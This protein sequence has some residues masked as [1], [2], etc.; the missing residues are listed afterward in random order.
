MATAFDNLR[1]TT[2]F[3]LRLFG[4]LRQSGVEI[5]MQQTIA[6]MHAIALLGVV[7][8]D[9]LK[10]IYKAT[11]INRREDLF[12]L[13]RIYELL[14]KAYLAP[15]TTAQDDLKELDE[16][17]VVTIKR[18]QQSDGE[19]P[20]DDDAE[21]AETEGYSVRE[22]DHH[23]DFQ[24]IPKEEVPAV[25]VELEKIARKYA[26]IARRKKKAKRS[27]DIDLRASV[28]DSLKFDGEIVTWRY[29]QKTPTHSRFVILS[30][31]SGSM[32]I[33]SV[34][35]LNFLYLLHKNQKMKVESFVFSTR[36]QALT[37]YFRLRN[38]Q[39]MLKNVSMHFSG[40][41]GGTKIGQAIET[42][43]REFSSTVTPKTTVIIMS[44]G[45]DTGD[46]ALLDR[47]MAR[48]C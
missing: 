38:F 9:E 39:E 4:L 17:D 5:G 24:L 3:S 41:S 33:Y 42:L 30:D 29:K 47:E 44:D 28:R 13:H 32:E 2:D 1:I 11:L 36:L 48:A 27:G 31:V 8:Q 15:R 35:L 26:A 21:L 25:M 43:N 45:W 19:S 46:I 7:N 23:K 10:G 12:Q 18:R 6:C 14:L 22:V 20:S 37:Q 34:F 16:S 40:W